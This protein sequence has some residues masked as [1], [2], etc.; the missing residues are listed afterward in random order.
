VSDTN[1]LVS[2]ALMYIYKNRSKIGSFAKCNYTHSSSTTNAGDATVVLLYTSKAISIK[3]TFTS[4]YDTTSDDVTYDVKLSKG[5]NE[6]VAK[7]IEYSSTKQ[8]MSI[9]STIPADL[10]WRYF[11]TTPSYVKRLKI[12][13]IK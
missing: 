9:S 3:G 11:S 13:G 8:S 7:V 10:K 6:V 5:W 4:T 1:A 2:S 12:P